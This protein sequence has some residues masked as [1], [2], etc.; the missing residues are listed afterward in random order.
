MG[1]ATKVAA[2]AVGDIYLSFDGNKTLVLRNCLYVPKFRK[3]LI[4]KLFMDGYSISFDDRV[5]IKGI[6]RLSILV[7]W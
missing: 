7:H 4:S 5:V 6:E 2:I 1:N 3:N